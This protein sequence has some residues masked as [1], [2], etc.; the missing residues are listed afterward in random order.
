MAYTWEPRWER[1][2]VESHGIAFETCRDRIT[3]MIACPICIHAASTCLGLGE[4]PA[5]YSVK[6]IFF[7]TVED[8]I[9]HIREYHG[10]SFVR[11]RREKEKEMK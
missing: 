4:L 6:N 10:M 5:N 8:L 11:M 3:K 1:F 2:R 7:F 9:K